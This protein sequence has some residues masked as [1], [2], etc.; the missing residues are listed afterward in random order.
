VEDH[1]RH[2][3]RQ[4]R[5]GTA[6]EIAAVQTQTSSEDRPLVGSEHLHALAPAARGA[7]AHARERQTA[8]DRSRAA[9]AVTPV[10]T[11]LVKKPAH[12]SLDAA[13]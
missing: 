13:G 5:A 8:L 6:A 9:R 10:L 11:E 2:Q 1:L 12:A 4:P 7:P 3:Q